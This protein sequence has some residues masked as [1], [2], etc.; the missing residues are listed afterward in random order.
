MMHPLLRLLS[1]EPQLLIEHADAY[2]ELVI[3][4]LRMASSEYQRQALLMASALCCAGVAAVLI[5]VALML[6]ATVPGN[7]MQAR[8]LLCAVPAAPAIATVLC[9]FAARRRA[10]GKFDNVRLQLRADLAMLRD[11][12][13][14]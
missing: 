9:L 14:L 5:G 10:E 4:D 13:A 11:V 3:A 7:A 2:A 12:E 8:W 1:T 6:W